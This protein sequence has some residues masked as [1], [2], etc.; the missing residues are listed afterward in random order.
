M[1]NS[2]GKYKA[3][4]LDFYG[5]VAAGDVEALESVCTDIV[6]KLGLQMTAAELTVAWGN[7]FFRMIETCNHEQF[8]TLHQ[9]ECE[10]LVETV[11]PMVGLIDP[12]PFADQLHAYWCD[13]HLHE[14]AIAAIESLDLPICCVS[15]ADTDHLT[16]AIEKHNLKFDAVLSSEQARCYK[17]DAAIFEQACRIMEVDPHQVLHVGD[18]LHS[19]IDGAQKFGIAAAWICRDRRIHDV[20]NAHPDFKI[21]SLN[22]IS[23]L[24]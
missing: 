10:S 5:T 16:S 14:E 17:P 24:L 23:E 12:R 9:C 13:P 3:I 7:R 18:S 15:N 1:A 2:T 19:D 20:G 6:T 11:E 21:S 22:Q 8:K 4:F